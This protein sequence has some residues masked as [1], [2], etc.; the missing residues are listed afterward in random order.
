[1]E[2]EQ[3][4]VLNRVDVVKQDKW[5]NQV[6]KGEEIFEMQCKS[7][8]KSL[9][10]GMCKSWGDPFYMGEETF[11]KF[12][13]SSTELRDSGDLWAIELNLEFED[14]VDFEH[15]FGNELSQQEITELM[16]F[17]KNVSEAK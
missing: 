5:I 10:I 4:E 17:I 11:L 12:V 2:R 1:M 6:N 7:C 16:V 8:H 3:K 13:L 14:A 15:E 9:P